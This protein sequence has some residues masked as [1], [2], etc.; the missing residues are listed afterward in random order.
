MTRI[1][2]IIIIII[3]YLACRSNTGDLYRPDVSSDRTLRTKLFVID[4]LISADLFA[5]ALTISRM[6]SE[7]TKRTVVRIGYYSR[8]DD[9]F[10]TMLPE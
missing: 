10:R 6:S 1:I 7:P 9:I 4:V 2:I 8:N 5:Y 3:Y